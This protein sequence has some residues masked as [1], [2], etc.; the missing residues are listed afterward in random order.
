MADHIH[1][2][3]SLKRVLSP[4]ND[5]VHH[6]NEI[7]YIYIYTHTMFKIRVCT[8]YRFSVSNKFI[9]CILVHVPL[10]HIIPTRHPR[11]QR[12]KYQK[13]QSTNIFHN[14]LQKLY[15]FKFMHQAIHACTLIIFRNMLAETKYYFNIPLT[16]TLLSRVNFIQEANIVSQ[17]YF[18]ASFFHFLF[19]L[20]KKYLIL[21]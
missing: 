20:G 6:Y 16:N 10:S 14:F 9:Q 4:C 11:G 15:F 12:V 2:F 13:G 17:I 3:N 18:S 19:Y 5:A 21:K 1:R 7:L 8:F